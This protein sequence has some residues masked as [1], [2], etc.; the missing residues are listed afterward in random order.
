M[1]VTHKSSNTFFR[2]NLG[3]KTDNNQMNQDKQGQQ[4]MTF[5]FVTS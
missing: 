5:S 3:M 2:I 4:D 1:D